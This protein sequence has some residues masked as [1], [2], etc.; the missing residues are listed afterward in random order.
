MYIYV[1]YSPLFVKI[2]SLGNYLMIGI[3]FVS[4]SL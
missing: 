2:T 3:L 1:L 4:N